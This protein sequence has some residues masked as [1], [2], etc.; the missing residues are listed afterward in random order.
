MADRRP[1]EI[2]AD[3]I[4]RGDVVWASMSPTIGHEQGGHRP[5]L[6]L[7]D[8]RLHRMRGIAIVV[9]MT[10]RARPWPTRVQL[11]EGSYAI[12]EQPLTMSIDRVTRV[13]HTGYD[14]ASVVRVI[15]RLIAI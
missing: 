12:A 1:P 9:P 14:T 4:Q 6:V 8:A 10:S 5:H 15:N 2:S 13:E 3:Q 11:G 7:S